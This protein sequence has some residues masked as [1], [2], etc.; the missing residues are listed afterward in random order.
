MTDENEFKSDTSIDAALP[1][2]KE[3][4]RNHIDL[5][6]LVDDFQLANTLNITIVKA[7]TSRF[8]GS[9]P[10]DLNEK[11]RAE[12]EDG[13]ADASG[14]GSQSF[15]VRHGAYRASRKDCVRAP[16]VGPTLM[17]QNPYTQRR[18]HWR[19]AG[20]LISL[21]RSPGLR[22]TWEAGAYPINP[23]LPAWSNTVPPSHVF[24]Q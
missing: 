9:S 7:T 12:A 21:P 1:V 11:P 18:P 2:M 19:R 4:A 23:P 17:M 5:M 13:Y 10:A 16:R 24:Q 20:R 22:R 3:R 14:N 6:F 15:E 8:S